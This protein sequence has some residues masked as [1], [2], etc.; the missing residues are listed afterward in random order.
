MA[1]RGRRKKGLVKYTAVE[2]LERKSRS[3]CESVNREKSLFGEWNRP[4]PR[5]GCG[6]MPQAF[7]QKNVPRRGKY[8]S[9]TRRTLESAPLAENGGAA[10][11]N[12]Q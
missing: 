7:R 2:D 11:A 8:E 5:V 6:I 3:S 12:G 9:A 1:Q 10:D 4:W